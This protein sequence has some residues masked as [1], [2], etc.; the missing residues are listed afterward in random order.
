MATIP[1]WARTSEPMTAIVARRPA[2]AGSG[3]SWAG[4]AAGSRAG[5]RSGRGVGRTW[6]GVRGG[7]WRGDGW[8]DPADRVTG[9][10]GSAGTRAKEAATASTVAAPPAT[11]SHCRPGSRRIRPS[12]RGRP[13]V[14]SQPWAKP[15]SVIAVA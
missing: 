4:G 3:R 5:T 12:A 15:G 9:A 10:G 1:R 7:A 13:L 6:E 14:I 8:T 2:V 11:T